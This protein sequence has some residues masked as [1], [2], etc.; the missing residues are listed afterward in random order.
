M[1]G[2]IAALTRAEF[3]LFMTASLHQAD[4]VVRRTLEVTGTQQCQ[5]APTSFR[6]SGGLSC[7]CLGF[8]EELKSKI[9]IF[10]LF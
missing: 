6:N 2:I 9:I 1:Y 5:A 3:C 4:F 10:S 7:G 8:K